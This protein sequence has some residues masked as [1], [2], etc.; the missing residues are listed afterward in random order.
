MKL[1][2]RKG[3]QEMLGFA[4]VI[5]LVIVIGLVFLFITLRQPTSIVERESSRVNNLLN[6]ISY[7]TTDC[8][9]KNIQQI[10]IACGRGESLTCDIGPC[11]FARREVQQILEASLEGDYIFTA[12]IRGVGERKLI[13]LKK[14]EE[15]VCPGRRV[16]LAANSVLPYNIFV[17]L[18]SCPI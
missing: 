12:E 3:Q 13:E 17:K 7:Y 4:F 15:G 8:E 10:I 5:L 2:K 11:E 9:K 6:G 1:K 18:I 16:A 14:E